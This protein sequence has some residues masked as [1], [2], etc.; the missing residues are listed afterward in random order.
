MLHIHIYFAELVLLRQDRGGAGRMGDGAEAWAE[1]D[2]GE[3]CAGA[4]PAAAADGEREHGPRDEVPDGVG[5]DV[6]ER[7]AGVR[8]RQGRGGGTRPGVRGTPRARPLH[9]RR[10]H[11]PSWRNLPNPRQALPRVPNTH[12]VRTHVLLCMSIICLYIYIYIP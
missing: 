9:L 2:R 3:P 10:E 7:S 4:G 12:K 11:P 5:Q 6:R 1:P 8:A